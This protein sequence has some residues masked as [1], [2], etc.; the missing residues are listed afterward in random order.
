MKRSIIFKCTAN[1][2][3]LQEDEKI[4]FS[5]KKDDLQFDSLSFYN[6]IYA[7]VG[8][9]LDIELTNKIPPELSGEEKRLAEHVFK[10][11]NEIITNIAI[12]MCDS[13]E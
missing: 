3:V 13:K 1:E 9:S 10:C 7:P 11:V 5:I 12:E 6:N 4:L 2:Y 8:S